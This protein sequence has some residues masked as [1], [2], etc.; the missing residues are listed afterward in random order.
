[1][2]ANFRTAPVPAF[3]ANRK[4]IDATLTGKLLDAN[5]SLA[6]ALAGLERVL[7]SACV[8]LYGLHPGQL[9]LSPPCSP[10]ALLVRHPSEAYRLHLPRLSALPDPP[11]SGLL[12][13]PCGLRLC[14]H[15]PR[16]SRY[17]RR[18]ECASLT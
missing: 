13:D 7:T 10:T 15:L 1:M 11:Y 5:A 4:T 6:D 9:T 16:L 18:V 17:R 3:C 14:L 12:D 2:Y 8:A